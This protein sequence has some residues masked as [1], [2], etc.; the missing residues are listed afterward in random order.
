MSE[1]TDLSMLAPSAGIIDLHVCRPSSP[2]PLWP[3]GIFQLCAYSS[4]NNVPG[5]QVNGWLPVYFWSGTQSD[6]R[7]RWALLL[8]VS[9]SLHGEGG[10]AESGVSKTLDWIFLKVPLS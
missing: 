6:S 5:A 8:I 9:P 7:V 10:N 1:R 2:T 4:Q 3:H